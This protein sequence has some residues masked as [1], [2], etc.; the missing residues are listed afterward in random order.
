MVCAQNMNDLGMMGGS[1]IASTP[2]IAITPESHFRLV[3]TRMNLLRPGAGRL[4]SFGVTGGLS[5]NMEFTVKFQSIE[6]GAGLSPSFVGFGVKLVLPFDFPFE[7]RA[8][9]WGEVVLTSNEN[10]QSFL[11]SRIDRGSLVL[12]PAAFRKF[13]GNILLGLT[14]VDFHKHVLV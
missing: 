3:M 12:Q 13:N 4:N 9:V 14:S 11:P 5:S 2:T 1:G 6:M 7:S 10:L 8:A